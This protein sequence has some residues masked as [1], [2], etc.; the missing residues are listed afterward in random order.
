MRR[1]ALGCQ[2]SPYAVRRPSQ[3]NSTPSDT[4]SH[5]QPRGWHKTNMPTM[6]PWPS[7]G[8]YK[9][10][11]PRSPSLHPPTTISTP[12]LLF[13]LLWVLVSHCISCKIRHRGRNT[14]PTNQDVG[15]EERSTVVHGQR[16]VVVQASSWPSGLVPALAGKPTA[17]KPQC[18]ATPVFGLRCVWSSQ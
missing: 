4:N 14:G 12:R 8:V 1:A 16:S 9:P 11:L 7:S 6:P 2:C 3:A 17:P 18:G 10:P 15:P 13:S 5:G